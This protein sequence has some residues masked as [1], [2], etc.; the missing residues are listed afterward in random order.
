M[1]QM[2]DFLTKQVKYS[3]LLSAAGAA[4]SLASILGFAGRYWWV[5]DLFSHFRVQY[6]LSIS[7]VTL[8]LLP[9]RRFRTSAVFGLFALINLAFILPYYM[10]STPAPASGAR[11]LRAVSINLNSANRRFDLFKQFI[12]DTNPDLILLM[13]FNKA[14]SKA[15][16]ELHT[17][18]PYHASEPSEDNFGIA[19]YSKIPPL[20]CEAIYIGQ[21]EVPSVVGEFEVAGQ[22]FTLLG[23]HP[24]PPISREYSQFR[25]EQIEAIATYLTSVSGAKMLL[26]DLNISP[27]S[28][29]FGSLQ[30]RTGLVDSSLGRGIAPTWP[31][32]RIWLRIPIDFC[33][34]SDEIAIKDSNV[35]PNIGS[36]HFPLIV[37]FIVAPDEAERDHAIDPAAGRSP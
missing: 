28:S 18:Y 25:N 15:M 11:S 31:T 9:V 37:D 30:S 8:L 20:R 1:L 23:T 2:R 4:L 13:E 5:L 7:L 33:L 36:D 3:G 16:E 19:L 12:L 22:R 14:W 32:D 10:T 21:A 27:W 34:V 17:L 35:G 29:Y 6:F 26:G 24:L